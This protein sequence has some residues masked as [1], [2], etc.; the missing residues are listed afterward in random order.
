[1]YVSLLYL[2]ANVTVGMPVANNNSNNNKD[3]R[4]NK[5]SRN[6]MKTLRIFIS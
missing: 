2:R 1:M 5:H 4:K 6:K 3:E